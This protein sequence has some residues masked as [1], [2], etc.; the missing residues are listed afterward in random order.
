MSI[1]DQRTQNQLTREQRRDVLA[2][3]A[4]ELKDKGYS[5]VA[6][7]NEMGL[8]ESTIRELIRPNSVEDYLSERAAATQISK[9]VNTSD[10]TVAQATQRVKD[11]IREEQGFLTEKEARD[12]WFGLSVKDRMAVLKRALP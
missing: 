8:S 3:R 7:A 10:L 12:F 4:H 2:F 11:L 6:I 5:N 1:A 9:L